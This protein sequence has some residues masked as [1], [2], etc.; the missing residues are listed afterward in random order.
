MKG[1]GNKQ[2]K[3][4]SAPA[5]KQDHVDAASKGSVDAP[6]KGSAAPFSEQDHVDAKGHSM[7]LIKVQRLQLVNKII[8]FV[9]QRCN[10]M[11]IIE[12]E[13]CDDGVFG[14]LTKM[15][16]RIYLDRSVFREVDNVD[17]LVFSL[18][19]D[20]LHYL[21]IKF[22]DFE[23]RLVA[24][25]HMIKQSKRGGVALSFDIAVPSGGLHDGILAQW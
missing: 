22:I 15:G 25:L 16:T 1:K 24:T 20:H 6:N 17:K 19:L 3:K 7:H 14:T 21:P 12:Y 2:G 9:L 4:G 18:E 11:A 5:S 13:E 8:T 10:N 23:K